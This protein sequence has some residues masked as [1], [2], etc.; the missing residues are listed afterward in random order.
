MR[1]RTFVGQFAVLLIAM[2]ALGAAADAVAGGGPGGGNGGGHGGG[3][4]GGGGHSGGGGHASSGASRGPGGYHAAHAGWGRGWGHD[5]W[6]RGHPGHGWWRGGC[7]AWGVGFGLGWFVPFLPWGY[8]TLWWNDVPYYYA[9]SNYYTW[10]DA[11]GEYQA[12][13]PPEDAGQAAALATDS[14][15]DAGFEL[16]A[17]PKGGQ[18]DEQQA[19]DRDECRRWASQQT[20]FDP[21]RTLDDPP[22]NALTRRQAYLRAEAACLEARN[23]TVR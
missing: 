11:V 1:T 18:S 19:R 6:H 3:G 21:A 23:Y 14:S 15:A 12:V 2:L 22:G 4:G 17:Y 20:G 9:G 13:E 7:C 16:Y 5:G 10:D 8:E